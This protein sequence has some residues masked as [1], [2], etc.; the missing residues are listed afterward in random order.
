MDLCKFEASLNYRTFQGSRATQPVAVP[1]P[2]LL[3]RETARAASE[4]EHQHVHL[5]R[6]E[7][8]VSKLNL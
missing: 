2:Q 3:L 8:S 1:L 5:Q 4:T 7:G 6:K